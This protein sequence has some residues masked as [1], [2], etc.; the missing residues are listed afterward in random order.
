MITDLLAS[1]SKVTNESNPFHQ[2]LNNTIGYFFELIDDE[3][4]N[5]N[6]AMFIQE[7]TGKMLDLHGIDYGVKRL[8]NESDEDFRN[9][10]ILDSLDRFT[11]EWLYTLFDLQLLTYNEDYNQD[12]MLLSDNHYLNNKYYIS[13]SDD[14]WNT[15]LKKF[16]VEGVLVRL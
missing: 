2:F 11:L 6:T 12:T 5:I 14:V 7:A 3:I 16:I 13:C 4:D 1:S 10:L 9:R 8:P 15:I